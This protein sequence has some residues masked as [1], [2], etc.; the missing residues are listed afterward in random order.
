MI[1]LT[2]KIESIYINTID[3]YEM[4]ISSHGWCI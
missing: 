2:Q 3:K 4:R 1:N